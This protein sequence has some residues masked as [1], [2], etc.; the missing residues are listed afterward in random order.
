MPL[1]LLR[2]LTF[3]HPCRQLT[4]TGLLEYHYE[5]FLYGDTSL[6]Q[7]P[8]R[9]R[10]NLLATNLS[11][12]CLCAFTRDG[13]LMQRRLPG[14]RSHFD[15]IHTGL[16]TVP[17]AV[18]AS[19]AFPGFF[20]PMELRGEDVG[21]DPGQFGRIAFTDGGVYDNLGVRMFRCLE[22][23]W[24]ASEVRL[25]R[26]DLADVEQ[27][28]RAL[29]EAAQ[30]AADSP[31]HRLAQMMDL[32]HNGR[33]RPA[34]SGTEPVQVL[35][36]GLWDVMNHE[37]L[38]REPVFARLSLPN[39]DVEPLRAAAQHDEIDAGEQLCLN[40]QLVEAA[41][42]QSTGK[43]CFRSL[44][45]CFDAVLVSDAGKQFKISNARA[46]GLITT[47][48]RATEI[49]MDRVW[50]LEIDT[51]TGTPGFVFAPISRVVEA[52]EDPTVLHPEVQRMTADIR[53]DLDRF[54]PLEISSL[55]RHGY[56]V[57]RS[58]CRSR[59]DLFGTA[60]PTSAPWDPLASK[61]KK[62][63][64]AVPAGSVSPTPLPAERATPAT[65]PETKESRALQ[66]SG[67][68]RLW[69]TLLDYRD[70]ISFIYVPLLIPILVVLPYYV[71]KWYH[72]AQLAHQLME[73]MA[74]SN[75]DYAVMRKL[76]Q[77]GPSPAF[78]GMPVEEVQQLAP[79]DFSSFEVIADT[80]ILDFRAWN[81]TGGRAEGSF[82]YGYR[83]LR[84][85]KK[86]STA[87]QF[88]FRIH[89]PTTR[90]DL[91]TLNQRIPATLRL[92]RDTT[93]PEGKQMNVFE[94]AFDLSMVPAREVVD[95]PI[96]AL[97]HEPPPELLETVK[98]YVDTETGL[99]NYWLLLP[100]GKKSESF[101]L[102]HYPVGN[103]SA[104]EP[105]VP[106]N[107][108]NALDGQLLSFSLLSVKPGFVY[109]CR[110]PAF[111]FVGI[112]TGR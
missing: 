39:S 64:V 38:A 109:E 59:P 106:A 27:V 94:V 57:G 69:S 85:Q 100:E 54:S 34:Q 18:T 14:R 44:N 32:P 52:E 8:V 5:K 55:I 84:V 35:L 108:L 93:S 3:L 23:S 1:R 43:P 37:N 75:L 111:R 47:G 24:L 15:R 29:Q 66:Q 89:T 102:F 6:F 97:I 50:A 17:M 51:F 45:V 41:F 56:C 19:S 107:Q 103:P 88:V 46:G 7:L 30:A 96:E 72:R 98:V 63:S 16:A 48:M 28:G 60:M 53:T 79:P 73:S 11:E 65:A 83:R 67:K 76:L 101:D 82:A 71:A 62:S 12:G 70:W 10:L 58:A 81:D 91:R 78:A 4:R 21:A 36:D 9:P 99:L 68:R 40:R 90:L 104:R 13:L 61:D 80:R 77:E 26:E 49:A 112:P 25:E 92:L 20:P 42:R 110:W 87:K 2:K 31:L 86:E 74:Q 105:I 33:T 95:L 22:R